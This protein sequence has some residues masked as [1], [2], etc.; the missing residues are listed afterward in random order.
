MLENYQ[1]NKD[2][3][4]KQINVKNITYDRNYV[5]NSYVKYGE[6]SNYISYLR[7]GYLIGQIKIIPQSILD[8]GYGSGAFLEICKRSIPNCYGYDVGEYNIPEKCI[9]INDIFS[10]HFDVISFFDS[11]E[12][13]DD[14]Y[15]LN[16]LKCKYIIISVPECHYFSDEWFKTWK[17]RRENEHIWH[18]SRKALSKFMQTQNY[19]TIDVS[20]IEDIIRKPIDKNT[21]ILTGIF[22]NLNK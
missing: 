11:L 14:I 9:R 5:L 21:N 16:K 3:I 1:I 19:L 8:F 10:M 6:L 20:N 17:H 15:F 12:H 4:V 18:F 2:G 7:Y 13:V 22:K